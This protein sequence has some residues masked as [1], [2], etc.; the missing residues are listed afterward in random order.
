MVFPQRKGPQ[1]SAIIC[2]DLPTVRRIC[3]L[4]C[5]PSKQEPS[6]DEAPLQCTAVLARALDQSPLANTYQWTDAE[7]SVSTA[8]VRSLTSKVTRLGSSKAAGGA[9]ALAAAGGKGREDTA[10]RGGGGDHHPGLVGWLL[11]ARPAA[12]PAPSVEDAGSTFFTVKGRS[13]EAHAAVS[14]DFRAGGGRGRGGGGGGGGLRP[15]RDENGRNS[16]RGG[17]LVSRTAGGRGHTRKVP[18]AWK[19]GAAAVSPGLG[20]VEEGGG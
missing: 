19:P 16:L 15:R 18:G 13:R 20:L 10:G 12:P 1:R 8:L 17:R 14:R 3:V 11:G 9:G 6:L 2:K 4:K 5:I 7:S